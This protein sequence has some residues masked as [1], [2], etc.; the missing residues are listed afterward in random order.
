MNLGPRERAVHFRDIIGLILDLNISF[1]VRVVSGN[2]NIVQK[3]RENIL[4]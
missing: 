2:Q 4:H 3:I 1:H